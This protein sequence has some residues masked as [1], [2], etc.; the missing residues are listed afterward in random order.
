MLAVRIGRHVR[1]KRSDFDRVVETS[2]SGP[3][4]PPLAGIWEGMSRRL[5]LLTVA[6]KN[7]MA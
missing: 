6:R 1:I 2:Y 4:S 7:V 3:T 5:K